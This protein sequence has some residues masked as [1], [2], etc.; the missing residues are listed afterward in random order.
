LDKE[1]KFE[2][3]WEAV[4]QIFNQPGIADKPVALYSICGK[5]RSGKS[6]ILFIEFVSALS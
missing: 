3:H 5:R 2:F 1:K 4:E 6:Q